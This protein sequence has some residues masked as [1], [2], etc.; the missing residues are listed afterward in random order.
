MATVTNTIKLPGG[1]TPTSAAVEI[2]LVASTTAKAAGWVTATDVT[3]LATYRPTVTDGAWSADLTPNADITPS[4]T[5]YRINEYANGKRYT[6]HISVGSG[7]GTV[8]DLLV[9]APASLASAALTDHIADTTSVHGI[10]DTSALYRSG[11]TDVAV[12]DGGTGASTAAEARTNLGTVAASNLDAPAQFT[13]GVRSVVTALPAASFRPVDTPSLMAVDIMPTGS[14]TENPSEGFAWL[15]I[16]ST[17]ILDNFDA[18]TCAHVGVGSSYVE[19][20]SRGYGLTAP[21]LKLAVGASNA[22]FVTI[23]SNAVV[24]VI[25]GSIQVPFIRAAAGSPVLDFR[26]S[27]TVRVSAAVAADNPLS[28]KAAASQTGDMV[29]V[30]DSANNNHVRITAADGTT[31]FADVLLAHAARPTTATTGFLHVGSCAGTPT[32]VPANLTAGAV[33]VIVDTTA[34][35][36]WA[37]IGGTW[38][39]VTL[40]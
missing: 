36:L 34:S 37:Y 19:F 5:V 32:G 33:P 18:T 15:D 6:H 2:E 11:G 9:D 7:G 27:G 22:N 12:A 31:K 13:L 38:K 30:M 21:P 26:Q 40:T 20:G 4:G 8:H 35:K 1:I 10:T 28:T 23:N 3:I 17:D 39:S 29:K 14:P 25:N 16:C 24:E